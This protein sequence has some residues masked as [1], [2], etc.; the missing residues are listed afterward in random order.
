MINIYRYQYWLSAR[1]V[2]K[3][4]YIGYLQ[5]NPISCIS[6]FSTI[7]P[8]FWILFYHHDC[9]LQSSFGN[10]T[11]SLKFNTQHCLFFSNSC[12]VREA[13][14]HL[15]WGFK[16]NGCHISRDNKVVWGNSVKLSELAWIDYMCSKEGRVHREQK[17]D[18]DW[19]LD[20]KC[21]H[22]TGWLCDW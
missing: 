21:F 18:L 2:V 14:S 22:L 6:N 12:F 9:L 3:Y 7:L 19:S 1:W 20:F 17:G 13:F 15:N 11:K 8:V 16:D 4:W 5:K 10:Y